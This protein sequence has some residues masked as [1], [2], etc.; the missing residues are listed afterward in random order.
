MVR[1]ARGRSVR[2]VSDLN[3]Y[4]FRQ[5]PPPPQRLDPDTLA[6]AVALLVIVV[7]AALLAIFAV[8][9]SKLGGP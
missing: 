4:E 7:G 9:G 2:A 6:F 5:D 1:G 8:L 3:D